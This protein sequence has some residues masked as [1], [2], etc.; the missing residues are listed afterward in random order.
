[1]KKILL[2]SLCSALSLSV[3][4]TGYT[5]NNKTKQEPA[6]DHGIII[7]QP[8]SPVELDTYASNGLALINKIDL[9]AETKSY[10]NSLSVSEE[11][12][13][14]ISAIG[15]A[16]YNTPKVIYKSVIPE[17]A[18]S[19][20]LSYSETSDV[21]TE[22]RKII[23]NKYIASIPSQINAS[24]GSSMLA[25]TSIV[26]LSESSL[27]E[28]ITEPIVYVYI[29]DNDYSAI[30]T[31]IPGKDGSVS[32]SAGFVKTELLKDI[33]SANELSAFFE[34]SLSIKGLSFREVSSK[35]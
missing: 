31:V 28:D 23:E 11:L 18:A 8:I 15:E 25:A 34:G 19:K 32:S 2:V 30:V 12:N 3:L 13:T 14:I 22:V 9:L 24:S 10:V 16:S 33:S 5:L 29:Y 27:E 20:A 21:S 4:S 35:Q 26:S 6:R 17:E 1:M 7:S